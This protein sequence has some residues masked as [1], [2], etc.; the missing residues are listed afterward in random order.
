MTVH[1]ISL[2]CSKSATWTRATTTDCIVRLS[3]SLRVPRN[4]A[5][6]A[7]CAARSSAL[8]TTPEVERARRLIAET[9]TGY[10]IDTID[11]VEDTIVYDGAPHDEFVSL[12][13]AGRGGKEAGGNR[14]V[15]HG[16]VRDMERIWMQ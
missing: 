4:N 5:R 9:C 13:V 7:R 12:K 10:V 15:V 2:I 6:A 1:S 11:T 3:Y 8:L 14:R 16:S